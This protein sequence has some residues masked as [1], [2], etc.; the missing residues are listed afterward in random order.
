MEDGSLCFRYI[1]PSSYVV[2]LR[3]IGIQTG[4]CLVVDL[5]A[6]LLTE[7]EHV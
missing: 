2:V 3:T 5:L 4:C 7:P 6:P 1:N